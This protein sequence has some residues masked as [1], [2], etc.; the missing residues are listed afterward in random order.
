MD[1]TRA[2]QFS[3]Q[4]QKNL[5]RSGAIA[6]G[7][8]DLIPFVGAGRSAMEGDYGSAAMQGLLDVAPVGKAVGLAAAPLMGAIKV[9][10][11]S[12]HTFDKFDM[13][14]IGTGEGAQAYGHGLYFAES[15]KVASE[16][17]EKLGS[18][19]INV[20]I[21]AKLSGKN[22]K[23]ILE[24]MY[25]NKDKTWYENV[26]KLAE[27]GESPK[28]SG[29]LYEVSLRYPGAREATDPLGPQHFLDWDKP[30]SEQSEPVRKAVE[31]IMA[32]RAEQ[33]EAERLRLNQ[34]S[35]GRLTHPVLSKIANK[36]K[37]A[38]DYKGSAAIEQLVRDLGGPA[39]ASE[40]L[41][42]Q[43]IPGI[44]YLDAMSREKGGTSNY[45][46]FDDQLAEILR[47][48]KGLLD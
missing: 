29:N 36:P 22:Q 14:K 43:G 42:Q 9:F 40:Y 48:N 46:I 11:G 31:S 25:P 44:R 39:K 33:A 34:M 24:K 3:K 47:R 27:S 23:T 4:A 18:A 21:A 15:P 6:S 17:A 38:L 19:P 30:L 10:H 26:I 13:S 1:R 16:Y 32:K 7:L 12:P 41:K 2:G 28:A 5:Q 45:V 20:A 35:P 37:T 8:L